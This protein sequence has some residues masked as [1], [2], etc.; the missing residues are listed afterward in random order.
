VTTGIVG[1]ATVA[2]VHL[3]PLYR[4]FAGLDAGV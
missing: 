2:A 4:R 1:V 3:I